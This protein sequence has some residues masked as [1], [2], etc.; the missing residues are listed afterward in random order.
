MAERT[1]GLDLKH[2][3]LVMRQIGR[4]HAASVVLQQNSPDRFICFRES[5]FRSE[6]FASCKQIFRTSLTN[7]AKE[8]E[9]WPRYKE[10]LNE[11]LLNMADSAYTRFID[12]VK[13]DEQEFNVLCHGDLWLNNMMFRYSEES[14][15]LTEVR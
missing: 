8:V 4:Y 13:R 14:G 7:L 5:M 10:A 6:G 1:L 3:L 2:C 9:K 11:K 15:E 12:S